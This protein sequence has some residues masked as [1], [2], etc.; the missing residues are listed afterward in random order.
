MGDAGEGHLLVLADEGVAAD[1]EDRDL[2]RDGQ[3]G[4]AADGE[5]AGGV[6]VVVGEHGKRLGRGGDDADV[7]ARGAIRRERDKVLR[8][9]LFEDIFVIL[10]HQFC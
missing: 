7:K 2:L 1:A 9:Y 3:A 10:P 8:R 5:Q 4:G 6:R